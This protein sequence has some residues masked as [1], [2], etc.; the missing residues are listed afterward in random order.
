MAST[1]NSGLVRKGV[2]SPLGRGR[3]S[4]GGRYRDR[5]RIWLRGENVNRSPFLR[6]PQVLFASVVLVCCCRFAGAI[7]EAVWQIG[8][9]DQSSAEFHQGEIKAPLVAG[10]QRQSDVLYM[11]GKSNPASDWPAFQP[12]S[13]NGGAGF[14]PHPYVIQFDLPG[15]PQ[16]LYTLKVALLVET[17]RVSRLQVEINGYRALLF[18]HPTLN[19]AG[20]DVSS[21]FQP[22]YSADTITVDLP[23]DYLKEGANELIL[24][25]IDEPAERDDVTN[26]GIFYDALE[27][28]QD[29]DGKF[30]SAEITAQA[31]PTIFYRQSDEKLVELVDVFIRHNTPSE[32]GQAELTVGE[33]KFAAKL[34]AGWDF[35]DQLVEFAVPEFGAH[36]K[37]E[38]AV[39]LDGHT[40]RFP[41]VLDPAKKWN[42]FIVPHTHLDVGYTDYQAKVAE[43]QSS[44]LDEAIQLILDHPEF[45]FSPDGFWCVRQ[46]L[47]GRSE[48]EQQRL[49]QMVERKKIFVPSVEASLLTGFPGLETLLRSLYPGFQFN[50]DHGGNG[51]YADITDV[52]SYSWS[53][54]SVLAAAGLKYFAAGSDNYRAP[55][56]LQGHLHEKSPFWWK[57]PDGG[58]ILM[59]YSRHYH[60]I[61]TLF[62]IPPQMAGGR[63]SLPRFFQIY[64]HPEYKSDAVVVYG[65]QVENTDLFPQQATL[66]E[67]WN[68][69]YA[70]PHLSYSGFSGAL[71]Y[72]ASQLGDS[73]PVVRGDG[74]PYWED[75]IISTARSTALERDT[76]QRALAAEKFS[77][78]SGLVNPRLQPED[79]ALQ[80]LWHNMVL[81]D[82]H[83]WGA[84]VSE[85]NPASQQTIGQWS[86]KEG[87]AAQARKDVDYVLR[88]GLAALADYIYD[89]QGTLLVFNP[90]SWQRSGLVEMDLDKGL[91]LVDQVTRRTV[92]YEVLSTGPAYRRIRFLAQNVPSVGYKAYALRESKAEPVAPQASL[93]R[94]LDNQ[95]YRVTLDPD[96]GAVK[97]IYDKEL[98]QELVNASSPYGF[99]QY[100]YV[101]GADQ[102]PNRLIQY[103]PAFPVPELTVHNSSEGRLLSVTKQPFGTV[104]CLGSSAVNTPR[105]ETEV[106]LFNGQK[107]I[108]F[109]NRVRKTEVFTK[110]GVY[111]AFPLAMD[112]PRFRYEIQNGI[113][114]PSHDQL[115]GAGKEWFSVQHWVA[116]EQGGVTAALVPVDAPLVALGDIVRGTWPL[117]FGERPGTIFSYVMDNYWD[118]N[119]AAGQGGDFTFRYV[120]TSGNDLEP[121]YLS[122]LGRE[123]MSPLEIDRITSQ[124]K[125]INSPRPLDAFQASFLQVKDPD[126]VLVTWKKAEDSQ[127]TILRFVEVAGKES[128]IEVQTPLFQVKSAWLNDAL[129]RKQA[130]LQVLPYGFKFSVKPFQIVT[131][132]LEV[133]T[134]L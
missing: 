36:T 87:F 69:I 22:A 16:G 98:N 115:P 26:P 72:I 118:T 47:A 102:T 82:E 94:T 129:E 103:S 54:A 70:Y 61:L 124:D 75:G 81:Y 113:V 35:G 96:S 88:R 27:L 21:A 84:S 130:P 46:F 132:R 80:R 45:R 76:E 78:L 58:R 19:Y 31:Q 63:D 77:T 126:A 6:I 53:Y 7:E 20:G 109:V 83:T 33:E 111:F 134:G 59:W 56:L 112:H 32:G 50:H 14:R 73:I 9:F 34:N 105:I 104:A 89:P 30:S 123:E 120:L 106:I 49:F 66:A 38:V 68:K 114:D 44:A 17:P 3:V 91:E 125:A 71:R 57:G 39:S 90:L 121:G 108:E 117:E 86:V 79:E 128:E 18:Q 37:A 65:T 60:Q 2:E 122:R 52:P 13:S 107:K 40:K 101:T 24:T 74:G 1:I 119:Y 41:V 23:T 12:G 29:P 15:A 11:I 97:S 51:D 67:E 95:Y 62:G 131:V 10:A 48:E 25:A 93:E 5:T 8:Q 100:L 28:D 55:V 116:A 85:S 92:P 43:A 110:E 133:G 64:S 127:G 42:L 99:D 4:P